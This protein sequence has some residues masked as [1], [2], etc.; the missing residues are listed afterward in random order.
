MADLAT[1][2]A[3]T[4]IPKKKRSPRERFKIPD[5]WIARGFEFEVA[6]PDDPESISKVRSHFGGRRFAYNWALAQVKSDMDAKKADPSHVSVQ[7]DLYALRKRFNAEKTAIAP[8]W[9]ANSKETYSTGIADLCVGLK[10][11][12]DSKQGKRKGKKVG[13][14][15][16]RSRR[17]DQ[18]RVRFCT[19]TMRVE[20]DRR[21]ITLPVV[22]ALQSLENTRRLERLVEVG[23]ARI[24][25]ATLKERWGRL[26]VSF[27]CIVE[28]HQHT[29][30]T[31]G[32]RAGVDLGMRVLATISDDHGTVTEVPNPGPLRATLTERRRVGRQLPR[33]IPGSRGHDAAKAKLAS[34]DRR[35][36]HLRKQASHQLTTM[37]ADTYSEVVIED[38][39]LAAMKKSMGRRAFRRSVSDAALGQIRPQLTYKMAWRGTT[40][41]VASRWFASSKIHHGCGCRLIEPKKMAK[42]LVCAVTGELLDRD[43]NAAF[44]LRDWPDIASCGSVGATAPKPSSPAGSGGG[45]GSDARPSGAGGGSVRPL[46]SRK[47]APGEARTEPGNREG[48]PRRGAA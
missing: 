17:K 8:W 21:T 45:L 32:G 4:V 12:K 33:R 37:L 19:G 26:F 5:G 22:G 38:L 39:D 36:V 23:K 11:W 15:K 14:P 44:N 40:L 30:P 10:N 29:P 48:T 28:A 47:A 41:T 20:P 24:L 6:W 18:A 43:V 27:S 2:S 16:F 46:Q 31:K 25:S 34:L 13:F 1:A 7:W 35:C 42:Q 3:A 9:E